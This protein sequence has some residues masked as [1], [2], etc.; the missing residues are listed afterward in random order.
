MKIIRGYIRKFGNLVLGEQ[1]LFFYLEYMGNCIFQDIK[2]ITVGLFYLSIF[3][4]LVPMGFIPCS[5]NAIVCISRSICSLFP[6]P[7]SHVSKEYPQPLKSPLL[8]Y[9]NLKRTSF[10]LIWL[11][12]LEPR[13]VHSF[14]SCSTQR[15]PLHHHVPCFFLDLSSL[16]VFLLSLLTLLTNSSFFSATPNY[17][18]NFN[19]TCTFSQ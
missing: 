10:V 17:F 4:S 9:D 5:F 12:E 6:F 16:S 15:T 3:V 11:V 2:Q 14:T 13:G 19:P 8:G 18:L 7:H 1:Q